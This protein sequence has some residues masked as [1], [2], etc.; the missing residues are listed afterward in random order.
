MGYILHD[1]DI[2]TKEG[3]KRNKKLNKKKFKRLQKLRKNSKRKNR[4]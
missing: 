4:G 3:H 2:F 1:N